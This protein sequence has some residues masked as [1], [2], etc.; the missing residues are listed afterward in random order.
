MLQNNDCKSQMPFC[1]SN[2][3]FQNLSCLS[4]FVSAKNNCVNLSIFD[5]CAKDED[6]QSMMSYE[7][8]GVIFT[9]QQQ[10]FLDFPLF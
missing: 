7:H 6:I 3:V 8:V 1:S 9:Q 10:L 2:I 5:V 4:F